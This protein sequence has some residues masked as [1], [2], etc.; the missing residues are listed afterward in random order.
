[1]S[2]TVKKLYKNG[3]FLYKMELVAGRNG[4]YN[5]VQWVHII[6]DD[7][8]SS[9]LHGNELVFTT[10]ILNTHK[11]WLKDFARKLHKAGVSAFVVNLGPYT[12][13]IP[14]DLIAYCDEVGM[15]LFTIPWETRI[16]DMTR[17]FCRRIMH[18]ENAE[19]NLSSTVK[20]IIFKIGDTE[21]QVLQLERYGYQRD[22]RFC[23]IGINTRDCPGMED[24]NRTLKALAERTA[25][26]TNELFISFVYQEN[27]MLVLAN[28]TDAE[29]EEFVADFLSAAKQAE[30]CGNLH[31]GVSPNQAGIYNINTSFEKALSATEMAV[32]RSESVCFYEKLSIYK[33]LY[34]VD[35][36]SVLRGFYSD[37]LGKLENYDR[38]NRTQLAKLL[39]TYL[40]NNGSLQLASEKQFVHRNTVTNQLK[41]IE[42]ITGYNPMDL[43]DKIRFFLSFY[44][45]DIL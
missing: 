3:T 33:I 35:D 17:D 1:M 23:F 14:A 28:Y 43:E 34:A 37:V 40:E 26:L 44:I 8:V 20:N 19:D 16:I 13:E 21:T 9:F 6:E 12:K 31:L 15:P 25:K 11:D 29:I 38:E 27:L 24:H 45:R 22:S 7:N 5:L 36:K 42:S 32:K 41:K 18:N 30:G 39:Q 10:G 2:V 4:L